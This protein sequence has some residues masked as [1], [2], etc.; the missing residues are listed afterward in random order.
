MITQTQIETDFYKLVTAY[1]KQDKFVNG[2]AYILDYRPRDS[3]KEDITIKFTAGTSREIAT[4]VVTICAFCN[5]LLDAKDGMSRPNKKRLLEI[6]QSM[7][8]MYQYM[9]ANS[10][11][12]LNLEN[13]I[14]NSRGFET[15]QH[16]VVMKLRYKY[17][18]ETY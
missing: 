11:Y 3:K 10:N 17:K 13:T 4:G 12:L 18:Q 14:Y 6:E 7:A 1:L 16:F 2:G 9:N 15:Q 5:D 8:E